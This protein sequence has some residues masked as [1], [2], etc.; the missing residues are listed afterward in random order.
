MCQSKNG[1]KLKFQ[2][3]R[4]LCKVHLFRIFF[5]FSNFADFPFLSQQTQE[6]FIYLKRNLQI[7]INESTYETGRSCIKR[8]LNKFYFKLILFQL[9]GIIATHRM[10]PCPVCLLI[11]IALYYGFQIYHLF[12]NFFWKVVQ[13]SAAGSLRANLY[14]YCNRE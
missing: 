4:L 9:S 5:R 6:R 8:G 14:S 2:P 7:I 3:L 10:M 12:M 13:S 11:L 1:G